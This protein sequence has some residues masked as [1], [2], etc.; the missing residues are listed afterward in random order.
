MPGRHRLF[1][2]QD[3]HK[4]S[5][6]HM[7]VFPDGSK[8]KLHGHN[9][10]VSVALDLLQ[11]SPETFLD[12]GIVKRAI[13]AQC[14]EWNEH[15][16]LPARSPRLE[17]VREDGAEVELRLCGKRYLVPAEDVILLPVDNV[18]VENLSVLFAER[19]VAR[20]G[21][22]LRRDVV[23]G[24]EV[25]VREARGQGGSYYWTWPAPDR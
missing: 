20:M 8:E 24:V 9:F 18:V 6:A 3:Q 10:N 4:F 17:V 7:T 22:A 5:V 16:L 11:V 14:R 13:E 19:F 12:V 25:E 1:V 23:A 15:L 21:A 2:G